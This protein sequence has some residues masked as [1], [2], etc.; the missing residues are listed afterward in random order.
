MNEDQFIIRNVNSTYQIAETR[1][2]PCMQNLESE[3]YKE[4][5]R[6]ERHSVLVCTKYLVTITMTKARSIN[7]PNAFFY[8]FNFLVIFSCLHGLFLF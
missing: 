3:K 6:K 2:V 1:I 4:V 5:N 7:E 8:F